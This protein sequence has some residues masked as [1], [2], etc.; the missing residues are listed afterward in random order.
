M[1]RWAWVAIGTDTWD[2]QNWDREKKSNTT[3]AAERGVVL[4][5]NDFMPR[6]IIG[7]FECFRKV[8]CATG[9]ARKL[10][11]R[12]GEDARRSIDTLFRCS[13]FWFLT[14][15]P[16]CIELGCSA[17]S[18]FRLTQSAPSISARDTAPAA[19]ALAFPVP[20]RPRTAASWVQH[21]RTPSCRAVSAAAHQSEPGSSD[22]TPNSSSSPGAA[23]TPD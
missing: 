21:R 5:L 13:A 6:N 10:Y 3:A 11:R 22:W 8:R 7:L 20:R 1:R 17:C 4:P 18:P 14:S 2:K 15:L 23:A 16:A 19:V 9:D 12:P